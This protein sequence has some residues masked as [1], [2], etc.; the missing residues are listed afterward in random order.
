VLVEDSEV[1]FAV[2]GALEYLGDQGRTFAHEDWRS[3]TMKHV[4]FCTRNGLPVVDL[5]RPRT[6]GPDRVAA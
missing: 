6:I 2:E 3:M 5:A 1:F 4:D